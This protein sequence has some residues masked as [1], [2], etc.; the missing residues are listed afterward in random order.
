MAAS[1]ASLPTNE[2]MNNDIK[3]ETWV[4]V[5]L[6]FLGLLVP[7]LDLATDLLAIYQYAISPQWILNRLALALMISILGHNLVSSLHGWRNWDLVTY[8]LN[9]MRFANMLKFIGAIFFALGIG[10]VFVAIQM[11]KELFSRQNEDKK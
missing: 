11:I 10:N 1:A 5:K 2:A 9:D 6:I 7:S 8:K 3:G 4:L